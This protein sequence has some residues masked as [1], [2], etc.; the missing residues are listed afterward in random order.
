MKDSIY[1]LGG[2][3][4]EECANHHKDGWCCQWET[5]TEDDGFCHKGDLVTPEYDD[6]LGLAEEREKN[7]EHYEQNW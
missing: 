7:D 5:Y 4:C 2:C 1:R 3:Y 6:E